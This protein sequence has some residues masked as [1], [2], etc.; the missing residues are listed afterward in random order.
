MT[1]TPTERFRQ[2]AEEYSED[3]EDER[4]L[5]AYSILLAS[6][7]LVVVVLSFSGRKRLPGTLAPSD[8]ALGAVAT[9]IGTRTV[10]K[11]PIASPLRMPFTKFAGVTGPSE[12]HEDVRAEGWRH[13]VGEL[14]T[15]P[16]CL[17]QWTATTLVTGVV[18]APRLT[19]TVMSV[20]T[21][22]GT[23][24]FLQVAY[25]WALKQAAAEPGHA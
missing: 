5:G 25:T 23:A 13:A 1:T 17:S 20:L 14:L 16:F 10:T 7:L 18:V 3:A 22:V 2:H 8:L 21:I 4:P 9:F 15:C 24:D 6:Y 19:R 11:H 12:L